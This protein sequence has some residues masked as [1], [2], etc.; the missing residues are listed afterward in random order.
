L[1]LGARVGGGG[2]L[3]GRWVG[4]VVAGKG[5]KGGKG[6]KRRGKRVVGGDPESDRAEE[7][8]ER[9]MA[10]KTRLGS[11]ERSFRDELSVLFGA[12]GEGAAWEL[13]GWP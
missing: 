4:R 6:G 1:L 13:G 10:P 7:A 5:G 9:K 8:Q 2:W 12:E 3:L 11:K